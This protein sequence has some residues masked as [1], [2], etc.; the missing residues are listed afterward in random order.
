MLIR[1]PE[2]GHDVSDKA[3]IC[4]NCGIQIAGNITHPDGLSQQNDAVS[5]VFADNNNSTKNGKKKSG[6]KGKWIVLLISFIIA[7]T[8]CGVGYYYYLDAQQQKEQ[9]AFQDA[10]ESNNQETMQIY[11]A[12]YKDAPDAHRAMIDS[13]LTAF[14]QN[15]LDWNNAEV[16]ATKKALEDYLKKHPDSAH[17][18]E[19]LNKIDS[20][21]YATA[22]RL[23]TQE[24]RKSV[25]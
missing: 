25:V 13:C 9:A 18:A 21:D 6:G 11:L 19:A 15:D 16:S 14:M 20:I 7:L 2:C 5:A 17:K 23:N 10:L 4:P 8:L 3:A 24:D 1:C 12:K 22:T